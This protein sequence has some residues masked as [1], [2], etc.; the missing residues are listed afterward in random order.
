[1]LSIVNIRISLARIRP[2]LLRSAIL[3]LP[4]FNAG[5]NQSAGPFAEMTGG[6]QMHSPVDAKENVCVEGG[7]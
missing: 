3:R 4:T 7:I 6:G 2:Y 5:H 1:M